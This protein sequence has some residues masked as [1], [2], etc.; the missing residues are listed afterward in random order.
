MCSSDLPLAPL[1]AATGRMP[2]ECERNDR[3]K[4]Q[5]RSDRTAGTLGCGGGG[6]AR[7]I[8][9]LAARSGPHVKPYLERG[10]GAIGRWPHGRAERQLKGPKHFLNKNK[11]PPPP[12]RL[13]QPVSQVKRW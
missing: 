1:G 8:V 9:D 13:S 2:E 6:V 10:D 7:T 11:G 5:P 12:I 4:A 3:E